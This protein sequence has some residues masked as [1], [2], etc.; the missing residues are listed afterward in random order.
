MATV[1]LSIAA[2][3]VLLPFTTGAKVTREGLRM[4]VASKLASD[5]ME[6]F[7]NFD[8]DE[9]VADGGGYVD[10]PVGQVADA[11]NVVL[12]EPMY[13]KFSRGASFSYDSDQPYFLVV[14][15]WVEYDGN[16]MSRLRRLI[17]R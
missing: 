5:L 14:T 17:S 10:E 12:T 3:G 8:F 4:T 13:S 11:N 15:V 9:L 6:Q 7:I 2:A 16:E 1:V